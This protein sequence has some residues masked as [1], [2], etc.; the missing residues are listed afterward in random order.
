MTKLGVLQSS[1][2]W[3]EKIIK[4]YA[5]NKNNIAVG[6][7]KGTS[8]ASLKYPDGPQVAAVAT[9]N[10]YGS[11]SRNI[12]ARPFMSIAAKPA[13]KAIKPIQAAMLKKVNADLIDIEK[14]Q[15]VAAPVAV[16]EFKKTIKTLNSPPNKPSTVKNKGSSNPLIDTGLLRQSITYQVRN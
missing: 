10:N 11:D 2:K 4:K 7:P 9:V 16:N 6:W 13:M 14:V 5:S 3:I 8:A 12:P 15:V 1:P